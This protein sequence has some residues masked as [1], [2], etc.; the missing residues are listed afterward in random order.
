MQFVD[1]VNNIKNYLI[2]N[3]KKAYIGIGKQKYPAQI[4]GCDVSAAEKI[5]NKVDC[6]L[7]I[8]DGKF[9]PIAL[10]L[11]GKD[12]YIF[13]PMDNNFDKL[14]A[15][16]IINYKK[17]IKGAYLKFLNSDNI[18]ILVSTKQGQAYDVSKLDLL[19][20]KYKN[21]KFYY[22]IFDTLNINELENFP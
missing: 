8:G 1:H 9:H 15:R 21:K 16:I 17:K 12:V 20:N 11:L 7:Y 4:L 22:F 2:K 6:F 13:N 18:G 10:G 5:K 14:D 3:N 19:K